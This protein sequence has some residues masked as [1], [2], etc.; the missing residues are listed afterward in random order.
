MEKFVVKSNHFSLL[1]AFKKEA[2]KLGWKYRNSFNEWP[3]DGIDYTAS[4]CICFSN[5]WD[6]K[7][8]GYEMALSTHKYAKKYDLPQQWSEAIKALS[9]PKEIVVSI[10]EIANWKGVDARLIRI[11]KD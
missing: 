1:E 9:I 4:D 7:P 5:Y 2:E 3:K 6:G 10:Q 8:T 11:K